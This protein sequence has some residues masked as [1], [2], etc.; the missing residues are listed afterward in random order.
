MNVLVGNQEWDRIRA[1]FV[2]Q[3]MYSSLKSS[4]IA[5]QIKLEI[6]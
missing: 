5:T 1:I 6:A 3:V 2:S 4:L